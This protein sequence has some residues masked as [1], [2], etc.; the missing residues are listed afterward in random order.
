MKVSGWV[1]GI[2]LV[3][4]ALLLV[5][6]Y[7]PPV[8]RWAVGMAADHLREEQGL[9]LRVDHLRLRFPLHLSI[10]HA[11]LTRPA[12][13]TTSTV[14]TLL[15]LDTLHVDVRF[16]PL[17]RGEVRVDTALLRAPRINTLDMVEA[18][19]IDGHVGSMDAH[20][21]V[22]DMAEG[23]MTIPNLDLTNSHL[24]I[25]LAD[26]VGTDSL[27]DDEPGIISLIDMKSVNLADVGID[28]DLAPSADSMYVSTHFD[29]ATLGCRLDL[30]AGNYYVVPLHAQQSTINY[31]IGLGT[32][33]TGFDPTHINI[34][35]AD[36]DI[37]SLSYMAD[38]SLYVGF[39]N[40]S[41][42]DRSGISLQ[43]TQGILRMDSTTLYL[44]SLDLR[45]TETD[46]RLDMRMDLNAFDD[47]TPGTLAISA[48]GHAGKHDIQQ[49]A[50][51]MYEQFGHS[52]PD[53]PLNIDLTASGNM[54]TL[55]VDHIDASIDGAFAI[56]GDAILTNL[57]DPDGNIGITTHIKADG[58]NLAFIKGF[59]PADVAQSFNLPR[60]MTL[61]GD[62]DMSPDGRILADALLG[63]G[64]ATMKVKA[65]Y[66]QANDAYRID[67]TTRH[68]PVSAFV[69]MPD[70]CYVTG[71]LQAQGR[72]FDFDSRS[73][74]ADAQAT[75][76]YA[77]FGP[78]HLVGTTADASLKNQDLV[79]TIG[80][81]DSRLDGQFTVDGFMTNKGLDAQMTI[82]L[83]FTD[84]FALG[85]SDG[86]LTAHATHGD[87]EA[88]TDFGN[89]FL[90]N[91]EVE[92]V[93]VVLD[94]DS[95]VTERF[96]LHAES[97]PD[98]TAINL[99]MS[100]L[101]F[102]LHAPLNCMTMIDEFTHVADVAQQQAKTHSLNIDELKQIM[103]EATLTAQIGNVNPIS[104]FISLHGYKYKEVAA[105]LHTSKQYGLQGG[106]HIYDL[107]TDSMHVDTVFFDI[108]QDSTQIS[109]HGG[110][111]CPKQELTSA[112][113]I[114]LDGYLSPHT[115][116]AHL[117]FFDDQQA[118]GIDL[119]VHGNII[120]EDSILH[121]TLYPEH[122]ILG[123][124]TFDVN[125]GN[126]IDLHRR[127]RMF[128]DV[129]LQS[130]D[131]DCTISLLANPADS[132]LQNIEA[133]IKNL[134]LEGVLAVVPFAPQM[135]GMLEVNAHYVQDTTSFAVDGL[136]AADGFTYEGSALGD[137][138]TTF[139]YNPIGTD[140]HNFSAVIY[141]DDYD[142][143]TAIGTYN[144][145]GPGY[146]NTR[147]MLNNLPLSM[148]S[149]FVPD[150]VC[151]FSG[152]MD[153]IIEAKGP[154]DTLLVNGELYPESVHVYSDIYSFDLTVA[155]EPITFNDSRL[156]FN[157]IKIYG[158]GNN[159]LTINGYVDFADFDEIALN[160]S[161]YG[162]NFPVFEASRTR[163][164][165][166]FGRLNGDFFARV[167]GTTD[168]LKIRGLVNV[169]SST[170][171]T[172]IMTNTPLTV[173]YRLDDIVTFVDFSA[174]PPSHTLEPHKF[175]GM[176]MQLNLEIEDGAQVRCEFSA[177]KQSYV[178]VQGGG[179][180]TMTYSPEGV[181]NLRGRYTVN[182]GEMKYTLPVI[183]LKTFD[184]K[185]GSYVEFTGKA[186]NPTLNIAATEQTK[187][188]VSN[189]D[190][191]SR[192][193][194]F[195]VGLKITGTLEN[196][197]LEFT[198]DAP[199]DI[200]VQNELAGITAEEKNKLA[201]ALLATSMYLSSSNS[202]GFST[203]NALNNF[204]QNEINNI[205]GK[206]VNTAVNVDMNV[207]ME[208]TRRDDGTTRTDYSF[209]FT[210]RFFSDRLNVVVGGRVN[211]DGNRGQNESGAYIDDI[212]LE[213]RLDNGGTQY[214][215][216]FHDKSYDNLV[217]G[218]LVEN[219]AGVL[220]RKKLDNL[221][222]LFIWKKKTKQDTTTKQDNA[223]TG[224]LRERTDM[225]NE[226]TDVTN[227][228]TDIQTNTT[229]E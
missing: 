221:S 226:R 93:E 123:Y 181:L 72:G 3:L 219:G 148:A 174:P 222:E 162:Q 228:R 16:W 127:N 184:L 200:Q 149:A 143:A 33:A 48:K 108:Y 75:L 47:T 154:T 57:T 39:A 223:K 90:V 104:K 30:A 34:A 87:I 175:M 98:S 119:G 196:M 8:Q 214:I 165:A 191:S 60:G 59:L 218:E 199:E 43:G 89:L 145:D 92:G 95:L 56:S 51:D 63:Y 50:A 206:A 147:V 37:D 65:D 197:G 178:N 161:L 141:H 28:L 190:G 183:P 142:I 112:F 116:D 131:D 203:T 224:E 193:V 130:Q 215:R 177:D 12:P 42:T 189:A 80:F 216:L 225:T 94:G 160:L 55:V 5:A 25:I 158:A 173:D 156:N 117:T 159:P 207:G 58:G 6:I 54:Q 195:N 115:A 35:G 135:S 164:S 166:L 23:N 169:L 26:S 109:F 194:L 217:E 29:R 114:Y 76:D 24:H 103:P 97:L 85:L 113:N 138:M 100:D 96:D 129:F 83:P 124:S 74:W 49:F 157:E 111:S 132:Q 40:L 1:V 7:L 133:V 66:N 155:D 27:A 45:T 201:V 172:Y 82:D 67:L 212:S 168:D 121:L 210:K 36:I 209:K 62:V 167:N 68:F 88:H 179:S 91:A 192:S 125:E 73:T 171:I 176:D 71:H 198:I 118:K 10:G 9:D 151:A 182:E 227:E 146:L 152:T 15:N 186:M 41:G 4:V 105:N 21:I 220:L 202:S 102:D 79:A 38:G 208:Q 53:R 136:V 110:A 52:W 139:N 128:A 77:S 211:A 163:K 205:A 153:G 18:L 107:Q 122:P 2:P 31:D 137:M 14:D 46:L 140:G 150:Q 84:I 170:D 81:N 120:E 20:D 180:M 19:S 32:P 213:W 13:S 204:L 187:A 99:Q 188:S 44:D 144:V 185:K 229:E 78:C 126:Y 86:P 101:Y 17:L 64:K 134:D 22:F 106:A 61:S 70:T 11:T 69:P